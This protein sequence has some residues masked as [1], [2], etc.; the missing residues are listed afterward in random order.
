MSGSEAARLGFDPPSGRSFEPEFTGPPPR[1][2]PDELGDGPHARRERA[3]AVGLAT[4][5]VLCLALTRAPGVDVVARHLLPAAYLGWIGAGLL[6][7]ACVPLLERARRSGP[8]RYVR[9]GVPVVAK[10]LG[11][12]KAVSRIVNGVPASYAIWAAVALRHPERDD[13]VTLRLKSNDFSASAKDRYEAPHRV[14]DYVTAVYL[15][16][17]F[18]KSLRLYSFLELSPRVCLRRAATASSPWATALGVL[19]LV[20][21]FAVLF[22]NVY[23]FGRYQP[24]DFEYGRALVPMAAGGL[25]LGGGMLAGLYGHHRREQ[26]KA[27]QRSR[28]AR[29]RGGAVESTAPF[30]GTGPYRW[31]IGAMVVLGAPLLGALTALCWCFLANAWLDTSEARAVPAK[32]ESMTQTTHALLFREYEIEFSLAGSAKKHE[33]WSTPDE[34]DAFTSDSAVAW[35]R[36]G[37]LG[38]PWV[39]R[40]VP[41]GPP[42]PE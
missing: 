21:L 26:T 9:E 31:I 18:E 5:G 37:R 25:V 22:A 17:R 4:A 8:Y 36:E 40:I 15:P 28:Q 34:L 33:L 16:G 12:E 1:E 38:W 14:G 6:L 7:L 19:A 41:A 24:L 39:A 32:V 23:A 11:L 27:V 10:I 3:K 13:V 2:I 29:T 35:V 30:L 20:L 42:P